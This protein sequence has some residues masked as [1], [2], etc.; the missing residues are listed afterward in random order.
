MEKSVKIPV[1]NHGLHTHPFSVP[2]LTTHRFFDVFPVYSQ[3]FFKGEKTDFKIDLFGRTNPFVQAAMMTGRYTIR[4]YFVPTRLVMRSWYDF[5]QRVQ[6]TFSDGSFGDVRFE[7]YV[8]QWE[9]SNSF[10]GDPELMTQTDLNA[11]DIAVNMTDNPSDLLGYSFTPLGRKVWRILRS[12]GICATFTYSDEDRISVLPVLCWMKLYIDWIYPAQYANDGDYCDINMLLQEDTPESIHVNSNFMIRYLKKCISTYYDQSIFDFA[13]DNPVSPNNYQH[14]SI[15]L[16]DITQTAGGSYVISDNET[17]RGTPTAFVDS[18]EDNGISQYLLDGLQSIN[19]YLKRHQLAGNRVAERF[20]SERGQ[21]LAD[22]VLGRSLYLGENNLS[23]RV[24]DVENNMQGSGASGD[25]LGELA[26]KGT[27]SN[28]DMTISVKDEF[29]EDGY[30]IITLCAVPDCPPILYN[31]P[32]IYNIEPLDHYHGAFD[33]LGV[34]AIKQKSVFTSWNGG[35]NNMSLSGVYGFLNRYYSECFKPARLLGDFVI[36]TVQASLAP[37]HGFR[38]LRDYQAYGGN[39]RHSKAF[40][41]TS[42][43]GDQFQRFFYSAKQ[44]NLITLLWF[45]GKDIKFKLPLGDSYDWDD[46]A[47]NQKVQLSLKQHE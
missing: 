8:T 36:S 23:L 5:D 41:D 17:N 18:D 14:P 42:F 9:L 27:I 38:L 20:Y 4:K 35:V 15:L 44:D 26:G 12:L 31:H 32:E 6:H 43:D 10:F 46:D 19:N 2:T 37:Y 25:N 16:S 1:S 13:W 33:K 40:I 21:K 39:I 24:G 30:L 28:G 11:N 34:E 47:D 3:R 22:A 45:T 29:S 7:R